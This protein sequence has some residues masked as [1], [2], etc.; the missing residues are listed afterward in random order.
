MSPS[1]PKR[2]LIS[3]VGSTAE[4]FNG[5]IINGDALQIYEGLPIATNKL[6][7]GERK[8]IPHHLLGCV[9]LGE[10][11]WTVQQFRDQASTTIEKIRSRGRLPILVGGTHYYI[12]SLLFNDAVVEQEDRRARVDE[13]DKHTWPI[14]EAS[15]E[16]ILLE[17]RKIDPTMASR[18]HPNDRR[19]IRRSLEIWLKTGKKASEVYEKQRQ[20]R[21]ITGL[22]DGAQQNAGERPSPL[23]HESLILWTY[24]PLDILEHRLAERV[25]RMTS[26]GL[27]DE[28][29]LMY[30]TMQEQAARG[31]LV[32]QTRG[33]WVAIGFKE[34]LPYIISNQRSE[35]LK[36]EGIDYTKIANRQY[37]KRQVRW[38]KLK[39]QRALIAAGA[40]HRFFLL[41]ATNP[42]KWQHIES[43]AWTIAAAF[44]DGGTLPRP[45]SLSDV[46]KEMLVMNEEE[47][48]SAHQPS[49]CSFHILY[50]F[51]LVCLIFTAPI[52]E[53]AREDVAMARILMLEDFYHWRLFSSPDAPD[54]FTNDRFL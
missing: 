24:A 37:A 7:L 15:T 47:P 49:L 54:A 20:N 6:S 12:Q 18:W 45:E 28:V 25:D 30:N 2:P 42:S 22:D 29:E 32:D 8:G 11:P 21:S 9:G 17:L 13:E 50:I 38:I 33:I 27:F 53:F 51:I 48:K 4:R 52:E 35:K 1:A 31:Q 43:Q 39:L 46:A 10:E 34:L 44:L 14:L 5:E 26:E 41:D 3:I 23:E 16:E 40:S 36:G 19:K